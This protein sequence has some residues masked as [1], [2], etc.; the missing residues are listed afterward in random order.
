MNSYPSSSR[1]SHKVLDHEHQ[2]RVPAVILPKSTRLG[3]TRATCMIT[4]CSAEC[5]A[6]VSVDEGSVRGS[7]KTTQEWESI[8]NSWKGI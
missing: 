4:G 1:P 6:V 3:N 7:F 5:S 8:K 2:W